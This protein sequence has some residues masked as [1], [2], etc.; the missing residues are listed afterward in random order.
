MIC[1]ICGAELDNEASEC[2][3]CGYKFS[4]NPQENEALVSEENTSNIS[5]EEFNT[6]GPKKSKLPII[7]VIVIVIL[8]LAG[9]VVYGYYFMK[10][11]NKD[12]S[13][14]SPKS[15]NTT[16]RI[17]TKITPKATTSTPV[18]TKST[19]TTPTTTTTTPT[20]T[21][22][23]TTTVKE[24]I[25]AKELVNVTKGNLLEKYF[26]YIYDTD[27]I[28]LG[29]QNV[30]S[31]ENTSVFPYYKF[32]FWYMEADKIPDTDVNCGIYVLP[33]GQIDERTTIGM[34][35]N[36]LKEIYHFEGASLDG[37]T[38]GYTA[39][40]KV[41]GVKWGIE[42]KLDTDDKARLGYPALGEPVDLSEINPPSDLGYY[43]ESVQ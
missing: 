38:F 33:G 32:A 10:N 43:I 22:P 30:V 16:S 18:S 25:Y 19:T 40:I 42:F 34:T 21:T 37:G 8:L 1:P 27:Y 11:A 41:N 9:I 3:L 20:T 28:S 13:L 4:G 29:Q 12:N 17:Q 35:Y 15:T 36:E 31:L 6:S 7:I 39:W 23:T 26:N 24:Y 14:L 5:T 2:F